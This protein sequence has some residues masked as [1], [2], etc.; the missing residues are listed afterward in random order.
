MLRRRIYASHR[1]IDYSR[2]RSKDPET[3]KYKMVDGN[4]T[5]S[6]W[7][8]NMTSEQ[9]QALEISRKKDSNRIAD[10]EQ[11]ARYKKVLG[12]DVIPK[13]FDKFQDLKYNDIEKWGFIKLDYGRQNNLKNNPSL[14]LPNATKATA[15][16]RKFTEYL[17][18][19]SNK[20]GLEK[21]R[22]IADHLGY[23]FDNYPDMKD[24][25]LSK[26]SKY[27]ATY[28]DKD[29]HGKR[30]EQKMVL[31]GKNDNPANVIVGWKVK[32][33]KTWMT[34]AYMKEAKKK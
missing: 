19:G 2:R 27:T 10:K 3:G 15:D 14:A 29:E 6:E 13:S 26:A 20:K 1:N 25:I 5:Y 22:L 28:K 17:F 21:G 30:Y 7:V 18:G 12:T 32:G 11:Y 4:T 33:K 24:E 23:N 9:K 34:T 8:K 31:Y 16:D